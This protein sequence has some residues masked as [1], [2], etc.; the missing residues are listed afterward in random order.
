MRAKDLTD[1]LLFSIN[2]NFPIL[3]KGKPGIGKSDIV[4]QACILA[5]AELLLSHPVV[6]D[7]TDYKGLPFVV[8]GEAEFLPFGDLRK[9]I[10]TTK[11]TVFFLDDL[12]Q[13]S[14]S[15]QAACMQ[16][17]LARQING[18]KVSDFVTFVAATNRREDK[19]A[20]SGLLEPV[21]SR[22]AS[23]V[24]L[25]YDN[26]DW[27]SWALKNNM[28]IELIS[29]AQFRPGLIDG[30]V[31]SKDIVNTP[32]PRTVSKMG[33]MQNAKL[34]E[35]LFFEAAKGAVGETFAIEYIAFKNLYLKLPS[36]GQIILDPINTIVP[37]EPAAQY[38]L[39]G[40]IA[41]KIS[42]DNI[43]PIMQYLNRMPNE[44]TVA[45]MKMAVT[46]NASVCATREFITWASTNAETFM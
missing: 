28:P 4:E 27:V 33:Q 3:I 24:E 11:K 32:C 17:L 41:E 40:A 1:F 36:I 6:S 15:V 29:F 19:A 43:N 14:P 21:K 34:P 5:G 18:H 22:F 30:F 8:N 46:K 35:S 44:L 13:A 2:N 31:P 20:V 37:T 38:A 25:E 9:L 39:T 26:D 23:I 16:L 42:V 10:T 12:G 7:P 45:T